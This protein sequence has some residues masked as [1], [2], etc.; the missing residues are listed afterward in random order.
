LENSLGIFETTI[1]KN[2]TKRIFFSEPK[3]YAWSSNSRFWLKDKRLKE[4]HLKTISEAM[5]FEMTEG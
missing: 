4:S 2:E 1:Q 5:E 3:Y